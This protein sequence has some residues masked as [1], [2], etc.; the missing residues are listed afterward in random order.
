MNYLVIIH[1]DKHKRIILQ[2]LNFNFLVAFQAY[3]QIAWNKVRFCDETGT[4]AYIL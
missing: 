1:L 3:Q 2:Q 4:L